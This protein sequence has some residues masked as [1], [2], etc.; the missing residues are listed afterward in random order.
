M[1]AARP[2]EFNAEVST[3]GG[4]A[5]FT[6]PYVATLIV[7]AVSAVGDGAA[8]NSRN[9][10]PLGVPAPPVITN[11]ALHFVDYPGPSQIVLSFTTPASDGGSPI[12]GSAQIVRVDE[13]GGVR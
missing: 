2:Y 1:L 5:D 8:S 9:V 7:R 11:G 12:T 13:S 4:A 6:T 10:T 3:D